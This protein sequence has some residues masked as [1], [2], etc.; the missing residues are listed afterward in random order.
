M[1][2]NPCLR[3]CS[4]RLLNKC[5]LTTVWNIISK[6]GLIYI[7]KIKLNKIPES[8]YKMY[9][10]NAKPKRS[11]TSLL[12]KYTPKSRKLNNFIF[13]KFSKI[14]NNLPDDLINL[15]LKKVR[16]HIKW[17]IDLNFDPY[18]FPHSNLDISS[19]SHS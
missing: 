2:G 8:I 10:T 4:K 19:N 11:K 15:E 7:H 1:I 3:W 14:H 16:K 9:N 13:Y 17:H 18:S 6:E 12:P 5:Q